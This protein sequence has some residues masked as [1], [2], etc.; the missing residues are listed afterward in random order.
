M[1]NNTSHDD[2]CL[3]VNSKTPDTSKSVTRKLRFLP[4]NLPL[5][6]KFQYSNLMY[7]AV[8][9][10]VETLTGQW[11]GDFV[12]QRIWEPLR[13]MATFY[14]IDDLKNRRGA[15]NLAQGY[16]WDKETNGYV[17]VPWI[18]QPGQQL[19]LFV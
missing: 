13:M 8:A 14:G 15:E 5:R 1:T 7:V 18:D 3:G 16:R 12:R 17:E 11:I 4:L 2:A 9:H 10:L 6:T 19:S